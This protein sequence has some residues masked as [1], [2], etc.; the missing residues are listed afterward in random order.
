MKTMTRMNAFALFALAAVALGVATWEPESGGGPQ[1]PVAVTSAGLLAPSFTG[2]VDTGWLPAAEAR[3][4]IEELGAALDRLAVE[5]GFG[6]RILDSNAQLR[7]RT[8][9]GTRLGAPLARFERS[10]EFRVPESGDLESLRSALATLA[11]EVDPPATA[12]DA[13]YAERSSPIGF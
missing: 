12:I 1:V 10:F 3:R 13:H 5:R 7:T 8:A 2:T 9:D 4:E 6:V 11:V